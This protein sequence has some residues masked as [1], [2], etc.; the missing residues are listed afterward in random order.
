MEW[1]A[2]EGSLDRDWSGP[3]EYR[4]IYDIGA[5]HVTDKRF[6]ITD[7]YRQLVT[8]EIVP[9]LPQYST[10]LTGI[11]QA[12]LDQ[13]GVPFSN[14]ISAFAKFVGDLHMYAWGID[15][16][17]LSENCQLKNVTNPFS[18]DRFHNLRA[19]F[20]NYGVPADDYMSSTIN[21]YFGQPNKR[22]SHQG[23]GDALNVVEAL[24]L[25]AK[26]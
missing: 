16:V 12:E 4:E 8:L 11:T 1:T 25:L 17:H 20:K 14:M 24:R 5:V 10:D 23:L 9:E 15:N 6:D 3:N 13:G 18:E 21:E 2:W 22:T 19:I 26:S 7:T